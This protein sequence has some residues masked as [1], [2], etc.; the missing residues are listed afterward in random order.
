MLPQQPGLAG[1]NPLAIPVVMARPWLDA[2]LDDK[3]RRLAS[4][5]YKGTRLKMTAFKIVSRRRVVD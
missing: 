4:N 3:C 1:S 5:Q 2:L